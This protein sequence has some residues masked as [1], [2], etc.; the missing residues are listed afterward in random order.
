[1]AFISFLEWFVT[2]LEI[3]GYIRPNLDVQ[4]SHFIGYG[5]YLL[6]KI[7]STVVVHKPVIFDA[8]VDGEYLK[9]NRPVY[10]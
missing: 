2:S 1:M 9:E 8:Q 7:A 4:K 5:R 3:L 10:T 6:C